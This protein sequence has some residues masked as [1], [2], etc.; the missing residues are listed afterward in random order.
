MDI[1][2]LSLFFLYHH[3]LDVIFLC[4]KNDIFNANIQA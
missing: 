1:V 2:S 4:V 3:L